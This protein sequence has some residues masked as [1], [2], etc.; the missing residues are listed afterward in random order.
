MIPFKFL[1]ENYTVD[2]EN[3]PSGFEFAGV[4]GIYYEPHTFRAYRFILIREIISEMVEKFKQINDTHPL[5]DYNK[6][7]I[8]LRELDIH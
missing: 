7:Y 1:H 4:S 3:I 8:N 5:W 6:D 2:L